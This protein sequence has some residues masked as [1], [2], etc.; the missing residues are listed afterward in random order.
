MIR[1]RLVGTKFRHPDH[2]IHGRR[3][4]LTISA[5]RRPA[6]GFRARAR[7]IMLA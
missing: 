2:T 3:P 5:F 7:G 4:L 6:Q 1:M